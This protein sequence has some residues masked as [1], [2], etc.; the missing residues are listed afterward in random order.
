MVQHILGRSWALCCAVL[1]YAVLVK[2]PGGSDQIVAN[3]SECGILGLRDR[4]L[5]LPCLPST[6]YPFTISPSHANQTRL[7]HLCCLGSLLP[8]ELFHP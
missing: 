3:S 5:A 2:A 7:S 8:L 6:S 1:C 4:L